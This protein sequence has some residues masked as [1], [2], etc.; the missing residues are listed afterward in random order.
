MIGRDQKDISEFDFWSSI[1]AFLLFAVFVII[2]VWAASKYLPVWYPKPELA[3]LRG[4]MFGGVTAL[5]S[6][7]AFA[8][9][10]STLLMQRRELELQRNELKQTR[11]NFEQQRF[12]TTLFSIL[13]LFVDH[14]SSLESGG[15]ETQMKGRAVLEYYASELIDQIQFDYDPENEEDVPTDTG[16][17][18]QDQAVI[19]LDTYHLILEADLG[20][21][22]RLLYNI[23]RHIESASLDPLD[24]QKYAKIVRA[25]LSSSEVKLLM[26]NCVS[27]LG[28]EFKP[29]V[30]KYSLLKHLKP[31][32]YDRNPKMIEH[33]SDQA[34]R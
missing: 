21:Y 15:G 31:S 13:E 33:F 22:F 25:H 30:E 23:M 32:V 1:W 14:I 10:I 2:C 8:G 11:L 29:W 9:L 7:L 3:G 5:F 6:G 12:E 24:S 34:F 26:F 18:P 19:Y 20:P 16:F 17:S 27:E 28:L 4:D